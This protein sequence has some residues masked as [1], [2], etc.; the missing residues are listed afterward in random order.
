[1]HEIIIVLQE[2]QATYDLIK[3]FHYGKYAL[4]MALPTIFYPLAVFEP[5]RLPAALWLTNEHGYADVHS[6]G[7]LLEGLSLSRVQSEVAS[8]SSNVRLLSHSEDL[9]VLKKK[10][11]AQMADGSGDIHFL[12]PTGWFYYSCRSLPCT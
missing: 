6:R 7:D 8:V 1:M 11:S 12:S 3:G 10:P 2:T 9:A 5:F 4:T